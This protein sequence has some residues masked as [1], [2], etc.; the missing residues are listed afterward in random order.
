M[1]RTDA[2]RDESDSSR[3]AQEAQHDLRETLVPLGLFNTTTATSLDGPLERAAARLSQME[4]LTASCELGLST[5][6]T[7]LSSVLARIEECS[8][9]D[10]CRSGNS[11]IKEPIEEYKKH[12]M[13]DRRA[14]KRMLK[15]NEDRWRIHLASLQLASRLQMQQSRDQA[16]IC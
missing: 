5:I 11:L 2:Q 12:L 8:S 16:A 3:R 10:G 1:I 6:D 14:I 7:L 15:A 13:I 9:K 4:Q